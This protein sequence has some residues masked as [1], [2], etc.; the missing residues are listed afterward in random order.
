MS[1][2]GRN[3]AKGKPTNPKLGTK[4]DGKAAFTAEE[5]D[6]A[7]SQ[8]ELGRGAT[9]STIKVPSPHPMLANILAGEH[10]D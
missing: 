7:S 6:D 8:T 3:L 10:Y 4:K 5:D 1:N 9:G 2:S